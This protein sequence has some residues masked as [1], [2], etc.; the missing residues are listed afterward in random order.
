[1]SLR[2]R[3]QGPPQPLTLFKTT[4]RPETVPVLLPALRAGQHAHD[5]RRRRPQREIKSFLPLASSSAISDFISSA[6]ANGILDRVNTLPLTACRTRLVRAADLFPA[7]VSIIYSLPAHFFEHF[8]H[9]LYKE[10]ICLTSYSAL[11]SDSLRL[12]PASV[13]FWAHLI[14]RSSVSGYLSQAYLLL[15]LLFHV[16]ACSP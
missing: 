15:C 14:S 16:L 9:L 6:G 7:S 12:P 11:P 2:R 13:P 3:L 5:R 10:C 8:Q 1:M 4:P